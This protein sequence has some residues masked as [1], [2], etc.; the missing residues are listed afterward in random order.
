MPGQDGGAA[1]EIEMAFDAL[2]TDFAVEFQR[3]SPVRHE[4]LPDLFAA[5]LPLDAGFAAAEPERALARLF[6][7]PE[8]GPALDAL[9]A[10]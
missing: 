10:A 4:P 1:G 9:L 5:A 2:A 8:T 7:F 3:V 6:V